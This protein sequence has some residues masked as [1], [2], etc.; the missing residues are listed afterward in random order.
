MILPTKML[1]TVKC[2]FKSCGFHFYVIKFYITIPSDITKDVYFCEKISAGV[3]S[4]V[5]LH[6]E[7]RAKFHYY[8]LNSAQREEV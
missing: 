1:L 7:E 3:S 4:T 6:Q 8:Q 2:I 5:A